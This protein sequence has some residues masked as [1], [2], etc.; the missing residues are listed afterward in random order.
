MGD[1][2]GGKVAGISDAAV[3]AKT[4][5]TWNQWIGVLDKAGAAKMPHPAIAAYLHKKHRVTGWWAQMVTVG[6][7]QAKGRRAAHQTASGYQAT[8]SKTMGVAAAALFRAWR[9]E[10]ARAAWLGRRITIRRATPN[11][12]MRLTWADGTAVDVYF[13]VKGKGRSQVAVD[14]RKLASAGDVARM[15]GFWAEALEA[16]QT[17]L[18]RKTS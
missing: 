7:E 6:Y 17:K 12:S 16:L 11:K 9:D 3:A 2:K 18:A 4:G 1:R 5:K 13:Y 10:K 14:H 8:A 15:K